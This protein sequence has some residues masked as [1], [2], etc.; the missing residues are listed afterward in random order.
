MWI[1]GPGWKKV[2]SGIRKSDPGYEI[3]IPD[4]QHCL[5]YYKNHVIV[6]DSQHIVN[7]RSGRGQNTAD[8]YTQIVQEGVPVPLQGHSH[9]IETV[10][11]DGHLVA[12]HCLGGR[13]CVWDSLTGENL[14]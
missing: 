13:I 2:V 10:L 4:P 12:S 6:I 9:E 11:T 7:Y 8:G 5:K 1:R 14:Y 3:N